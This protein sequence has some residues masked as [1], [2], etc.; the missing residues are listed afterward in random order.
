MESK[1]KERGN[2][3][4]KTEN[5]QKRWTMCSHTHTKYKER[6]CSNE[7]SLVFPVPRAGNVS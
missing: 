4:G 3:K 2:K 6:I 1:V 5:L 7:D